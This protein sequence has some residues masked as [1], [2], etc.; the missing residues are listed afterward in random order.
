MFHPLSPGAG[1]CNIL[2]LKLNS[3]QSALGGSEGD[4][5]LCACFKVN[6]WTKSDSRHEQLFPVHTK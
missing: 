1:N 6:C 4:I 3:L 5:L 2:I